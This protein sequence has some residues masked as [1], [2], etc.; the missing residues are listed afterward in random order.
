M[1]AC[2]YCIHIVHYYIGEEYSFILRKKNE[3]LAEVY[4]K[5]KENNM[6]PIVTDSGHQNW[7]D[8]LNVSILH[9]SICI[10]INERSYSAIL[11]FCWRYL[12][13]C[14]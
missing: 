6:I 11:T 4:A 7:Q 2:C 5:V 9:I 1:L 8:I 12:K 13:F 10:Q 14:V 3:I